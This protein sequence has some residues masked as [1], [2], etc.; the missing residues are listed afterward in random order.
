MDQRKRKGFASDM[1]ELV[2]TSKAMVKNDMDR[3]RTFH[4]CLYSPLNISRIVVLLSEYRKYTILTLTV[5]I[6][7][8]ETGGEVAVSKPATSGVKNQRTPPKR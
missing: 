8:N 4:K 6:R 7:V 2:A 5:R 1:I 3:E